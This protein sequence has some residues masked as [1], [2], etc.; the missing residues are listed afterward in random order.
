MV[1][2]GDIKEDDN[3]QR[4]ASDVLQPIIDHTAEKSNFVL[5]FND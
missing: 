4:S 1:L 2:F 3:G 5:V